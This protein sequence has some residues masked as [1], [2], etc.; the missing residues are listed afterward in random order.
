MSLALTTVVALN[1]LCSEEALNNMNHHDLAT[2]ICLLDGKYQFIP[3]SSSYNSQSN[4]GK[5]ARHWGRFSQY[6][7]ASICL[8]GSATRTRRESSYNSG[9]TN[10]RDF[11][12]KYFR[13]NVKHFGRE[14]LI[15]LGILKNP[16]IFG[17][18][19]VDI[20]KLDGKE[21]KIPEF[22]QFTLRK[23]ELKI[24]FSCI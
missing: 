23:L 2:G 17:S 6:I 12:K 9:F 10:M 14:K 5:I 13:E 1:S 3:P 24:S 19:I 22:L 20:V 16:S 15:R 18:T 21:E 11:A 8:G 7:A 4:Q